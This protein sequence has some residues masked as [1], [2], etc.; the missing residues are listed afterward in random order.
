VEYNLVSDIDLA[1]RESAKDLGKTLCGFY[2]ENKAK[3]KQKKNL[4]L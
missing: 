2:K 3:K 4:D 1:E